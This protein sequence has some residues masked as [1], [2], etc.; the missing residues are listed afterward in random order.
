ME[1]PSLSEPGLDLSEEDRRR[2][3][4]ERYAQALS[5]MRTTA[6]PL[7]VA[8]VPFPTGPQAQLSIENPFVTPF[9]NVN[10]FAQ[11]PVQSYG[12]RT[13]RMGPEGGYELAYTYDPQTRTPVITGAYRKQL[14]KDSELAAQGSY[15]P[16]PGKDAYQAMLQYRQRFAKGGEVVHR[17]DG[18]PAEGEETEKQSKSTQNVVDLIDFLNEKLQNTIE[19]YRQGRTSAAD[20]KQFFPNYSEFEL[21]KVFGT[22]DT[23]LVTNPET[24]KP[25]LT[26]ELFSKALDLEDSIKKQAETEIREGKRPL[27][28]FAADILYEPLSKGGEVVYRK[29]GSTSD[30]EVSQPE[31][32]ATPQNALVG[33][34]A[35]ALKAREEA[36]KDLNS[37]TAALL[38]LILPTSQT[39][40]KWSYGDPLFRMP[41]SGTGGNIPITTRDKGYVA[42]TIG[43]APIGLPAKAAAS[44]AMVGPPLGVIKPKG[45]VFPKAE[46]GSGIDNFLQRV[47]EQVGREAQDL[48]VGQIK[49]L[50]QFIKDK[51]RKYLTTT[52]GTGSDPLRDA[53][54][55]GRLPA[56]GTDSKNFR[57]YML[58]A[59]REGNPRALEDFERMYDTKSGLGS[60]V[61]VPGEDQYELSAKIRDKATQD[62]LDKIAK[63]GV[64]PELIIDPFVSRVDMKSMLKN[65]SPEYQ[66]NL[67]RRLL[68]EELPEADE[69]LIRAA[70]EGEVF[71]DIPASPSLDFLDPKNLAK[72]LATLNPDKLSNMSFAEAVIQGTKN[73][74]LQRDW[75]EV[76]KKV[77]GNKTVPKEMFDIGTET[78]R[79]MG[80]DKWVKLL[81]PQAV[82]LEGAAMHQSVGGYA[83]KGSYGEGGREAL[84]SGRAQVF[85]LRGP[86]NMPR[87]TIEARKNDDGTL[88]V[89]QI[90][91][92]FNGLPDPAD[93][94]IIVQFLKDLPIEKIQPERYIKTRTGEELEEAVRIDWSDRAGFGARSIF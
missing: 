62:M 39:V 35:K 26:P 44:G 34:I 86:D 56:F 45:G 50:N 10:P 29:D 7:S 5:N 47:E 22:T 57:D 75:D 81:T 82:Q 66:K 89:K 58:Q 73:T 8:A 40:E 94:E 4:Q 24:F 79:P 85:S 63:E 70:R 19:E 64:N 23:E 20:L 88:F 31:L 87:V 84:E 83:K 3:F 69:T 55:E 14:D 51:G 92:N 52:Y 38:D 61:A 93:Q 72:S 21:D 54:L 12:A 48:T 91:G 78:F 60:Y 11:E 67:A 76:I 37:P 17:K 6:G 30:G 9:V 90:K 68:G 36:T 43:Y 25:R 28:P 65:Y 18:S 33:F 80:Q 49:T 46:T 27:K 42:E 41:P 13:G 77:E 2:M 15:V 59:A 74:R 71:Y 53:L 32:K 16:L 1:Q